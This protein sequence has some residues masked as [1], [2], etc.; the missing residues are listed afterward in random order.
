MLYSH[1][2]ESGIVD[3]SNASVIAKALEPFTEGYHPDVA[4]ESHSHWAVGWIAGFAIRVF[5][6]GEIT[7]AFRSYHELAERMERYPVLDE[8][9]YSDRESEATIQN[10]GRAARKLR[11]EYTLPDGWESEVFSWFWDNNQCAVENTDD[12]GGWPSED[13]LEG[14]FEAL[15]YAQVE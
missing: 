14:A 6:N 8:S 5:K 3:F 4:A 10:I 13:D 11:K 9:D 12:Q 15:G 1:H 7:A 2:R